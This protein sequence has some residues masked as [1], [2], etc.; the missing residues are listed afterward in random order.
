MTKIVVAGGFTDELEVRSSMGTSVDH[1]RST[2]EEA[3]TRLVLHAVN[4]PCNTVVVASRDTDV[5]LLLL[6]TSLLLVVNISG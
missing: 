1:F 6:L 2:N 3:D 5:L 4:S